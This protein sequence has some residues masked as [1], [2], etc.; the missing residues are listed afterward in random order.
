MQC[1]SKNQFRNTTSAASRC[2]NGSPLSVLQPIS[3]KAPPPS[4][5]SPHN[6]IRICP[7]HQVA[8]VAN[9]HRR[10]ARHSW[11]RRKAISSAFLALLWELWKLYYAKYISSLQ[12]LQIEIIP[13]NIWTLLGLTS[14]SMSSEL[15]PGPPN[16]AWVLLF[17]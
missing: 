16:A 4:P 10:G 6:C 12:I 1:S 13:L 15:W 8:N 2:F 7:F 14:G 17:R 9:A 3:R 5:I 11:G